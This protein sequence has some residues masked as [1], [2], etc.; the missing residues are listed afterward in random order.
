MKTIQISDA[1]YEKLDFGA[2]VA[3]VSIA[4]LVDRLTSSVEDSVSSRTP[5][6]GVEPEEVRVFVSYRG[7]RIDGLLDLE[8]Q[9]LRIMDGSADLAGRSFRSPTQAAVEVVKLLNPER[10]RPETNGWRFWR[11]LETGQIIDRVH[12]R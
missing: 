11:D 12:R 1:T 5:P 2:R 3:G 6:R 7:K 10:E 8:T 9:R 4:E